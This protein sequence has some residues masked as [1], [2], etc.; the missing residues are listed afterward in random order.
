MLSSFL[1]FLLVISLVVF[2]HELGHYFGARLCD[3]RV[4]EF[5]IGFGKSIFGFI[6]RRGTKWKFSLIPL[7]G[8]VKMLGDSNIASTHSGANPNAA[9]SQEEREGFAGKPPLSRMLIAFLGPAANYLLSIIIFVAFYSVNGKLLISNVIGGV[10]EDS[11]AYHYGLRAGDE[12][13][14]IDGVPT[15]VFSKIYAYVSLHPN[16]EIDIELKRQDQTTHMRIKTDVREVKDSRNKL[17]GR[18]GVLGVMSDRPQ[19]RNV[20]VIEAIYYAID[21]AILISKMT[22]TSLKQMVIGT[23]SLDE[24]KGAITIADQSGQSLANGFEEFILFVAMISINIGFI[25]LLPIP[26]LDGGHI[27]LCLYE[28][29]AGRKPG[30]RVMRLLNSLGLILVIFMF[31]ISTS[32]DIKALILR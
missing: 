20:N 14:S 12:I 16:K 24:L 18:V 29:I 23:R 9:Y 15:P 19:L 8:Y 22:L 25:N 13:V 27:I 6:D 3:V 32:N 21:D 5:S 31:V 11:P 30:E 17:V 28:F 1:G 4:T 10:Q 26:I 7:G 2:V